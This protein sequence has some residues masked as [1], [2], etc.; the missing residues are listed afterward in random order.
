MNEL[1]RHVQLHWRSP[2]EMVTAQMRAVLRLR[3]GA[4]LGLGVSTARQLIEN[5]AGPGE[6]IR[7][8]ETYAYRN[9][10]YS[11]TPMR[12]FRFALVFLQAHKQCKDS[13]TRDQLARRLARHPL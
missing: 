5:A 9:L 4:F 13:G 2:A 8:R 10:R 7:T 11:H 6:L 1:L 12:S 3:G